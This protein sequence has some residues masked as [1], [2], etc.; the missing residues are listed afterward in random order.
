MKKKTAIVTG[1]NKGIGFGLVKE[2]KSKGYDVWLG[3][4]NPELG[5]KAA[6]E[7]GAHFLKIDV[8]ST[9]SIQEAFKEYSK[10]ND[11]LDLLI[12][13]AGIYLTGRDDVATKATIDSIR[14]TFEVNFMGV[15]NVSQTFVPLL[16]KGH[17]PHILTISSGMGSQGLLSDRGSFIEQFPQMI[18]YCASKT[19]V[20]TF[21]ILLGKELEK[22]GIRVNSICPGYVD[23]DLNGHS[24]VLSTDTSANNIY[25]RIIEN[26]KETL[27][28][29]NAEGSYPW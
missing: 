2:L 27:A 16:K 13:N 10:Q 20:N 7:L 22:D 24:G 5:Q 6:K 18:G 19:A 25:K 1:A 23:T 28:Y 15:I 4:R 9:E 14:E 3:A 21:T 11:S 12:N 17:E 26:N 8:T 29:A